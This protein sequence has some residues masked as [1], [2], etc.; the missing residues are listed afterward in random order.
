MDKTPT[1]QALQTWINLHRTH[2]KLL[3]TV[4]TALKQSKL[5]PL[6]WY[7]VL[8]E[9]HRSKEGLRQYEIGDRVLLN[10]HN[11]SRLIDRLQNNGLIS[12]HTCA[13]DGRGNRIHIEPAGE[14]MLRLMW[15]VYADVIQKQFAARLDDAEL[16][17]M[18]TILKRLLEQSP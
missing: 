6:D 17:T 13:E 16:S 5:P 1:T 18:D 3:A 14:E 7:D 8:L 10:K 11:L 12:R 15:P 9:L 4:E 2:R